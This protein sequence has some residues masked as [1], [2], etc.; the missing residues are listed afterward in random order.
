[1]GTKSKLYRINLAIPNAGQSAGFIGL[2]LVAP[3]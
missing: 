3:L 1:M 2:Q